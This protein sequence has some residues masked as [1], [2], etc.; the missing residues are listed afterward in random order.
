MSLKIDPALLPALVAFEC[1][2]RHASFS[3]AAEEMGLSASALSQS[4]RALE[5]RLGVGLLARTTRRVGLTDEGA[6]V[7]EGIRKGLTQLGG[8]LETIEHSR[9]RPTGTVRVTLPRM[10]FARFFLP[11]LKDFAARYPDVGVEFALDDHMVDLVADGFDVGVRMGEQ[12][13]ADM[14]A[15]PLGSPER[16]V[17]VGAPAYFDRHPPPET[18]AALEG[19]ECSRYRFASSGRVSRWLFQRDGHPLE[20]D[21]EGRFIIN[22]L[23]AEIDLA[24]NGLALIQT[25]ESLVSAD[26][27][28]GRLMAVLE[29]YAVSLGA[30]YLYYPSGAPIPPRVRVFLD[31]FRA[32]EPGK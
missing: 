16:L 27:R 9:S 3:R 18:P 15:L 17:T 29:P 12:I 23:H 25:I 6:A 2:A 30:V 5:R 26:L 1:V 28:E 20:V 32:G 19:H 21:V 31:H 7:L 13:A 10:A 11:R 8:A 24:R 22:D 4:L 14:V